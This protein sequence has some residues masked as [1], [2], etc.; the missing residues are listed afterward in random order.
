M[1]QCRGRNYCVIE[2][3][4]RLWSGHAVVIVIRTAV[5]FYGE[6]LIETLP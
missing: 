3:I 6:P 5:V 4:V 1:Y 2:E